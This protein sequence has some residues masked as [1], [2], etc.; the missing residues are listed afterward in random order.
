MAM[1]INRRGRKWSTFNEKELGI[2]RKI[3]QNK[4]KK[5]GKL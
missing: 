3:V 5:K 1:A 2:A 4:R